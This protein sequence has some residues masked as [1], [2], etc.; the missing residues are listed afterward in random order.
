MRW[1]ALYIVIPLLLL[2]GLGYY[3]FFD[4]ILENSIEGFLETVIGAKVEVDKLHFSIT[5]PSISIGRLQITNPRNTWRNLI[6]TGDMQFKLAWEPLYSG[7]FVIEKIA[8]SELMLNTPRKTDG[9]LTRPPLPGPFGKAQTKLNKAIADIPIFNSSIMQG[10]INQSK[11]KL[12]AGYQFQTRVDAEAI[13]TQLAKSSQEWN[14]DLKKLQQ[15]KLKL[16]TIES[17]LKGLKT[18]QLKTVPELN[19]ALTSITTIN[20]SITEIRTEIDTTRSGFQSELDA[21]TLEINQLTAT[22]DQD[23]HALLK[24]AK[25]P[26]FKNINFTQILLGKSLVNQSAQVIDL[27]DKIQAFI[28]PPT[29]NPPKKKPTRGGQDIIFP[30][31]RTYPN[32]LIKYIGISARENQSP[33]TG[34]FYARGTATGITSDP[35]IYGQP[36]M[37]DLSGKA[38]GNLYLS[39]Q[40]KMDHITEQIDDSFS[41]EIGNLSIPDLHIGEQ[42][43]LPESIAVGK[44]AIRSNLQIN[45]NEFILDLVIDGKNVDWNFGANQVTATSGTT[46]DLMKDIIRQTLARMDQITINYRLIGREHQLAMNISSELDKLFNERLNQ[47][48]NEK[49]TKFKQEIRAQVDQQLREKQHELEKIRNGYQQ[50]LTA[51]VQE[52]QTLIERETKAAE[53]KTKA[54]EQQIKNELSQKLNNETDKAKRDLEDQLNKLKSQLPKIPQ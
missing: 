23:Y 14:Q 50:Q 16:E 43:Y 45:S 31:R 15:T 2:L 35:P 27:V 53:A 51:K 11:D 33:R 37:I 22:A 28:P 21:V 48:I 40:G 12:L 38:P 13:N 36:L 39:L 3:F 25:I 20:K 30:G 52:L 49:F 17:Q 1:K 18:T 44:T 7:K 47:V 26:D 29:N 9:K 41:L 5:T 32:F 42:P 6:E 4:R 34:G 19:T 8:L 54:L 10:E 46:G 24:L